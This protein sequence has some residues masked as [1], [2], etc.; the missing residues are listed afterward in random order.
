MI[1]GSLEIELFANVARLAQD[2]EQVKKS[3]GGA[4]GAVEKA[5][6]VAR[7]ALIGLGA[8]GLATAFAS[9]VKGAID[10]A[11]SLNKLSQRSGVAVETLSQLQ[12]AA[13][14]ADVSNESLNTGLKKLNQS[15]A[16]GLAGDKEKVA[17]FKSLGITLTDTA[18]SAKTA[19]T[20]L[21]EMADTFSKAKDGAGKTAASMGLL[22]KAGDEMIPLLNG[23]S[24]ALRALMQEADKLGL[25]ISS[26]FAKQAEEF[27]DNLT[28]V[29]V[30]G[31]KAAI[32]FGQDFVAGLGKAMKA[33][34]DA[35]VEGGRLA[36]VIAGLQTLLTGDDRHKNNVAMAEQTER[37]LKAENELAELQSRRVKNKDHVEV[38]KTRVAAIKA[39]LDT[40][41]AYR[42]LMDEED[43]KTEAAQKKVEAAKKNAAEIKLANANADKAA[44]E[45]EKERRKAEEERIKWGRADAIRQAEDFRDA[46]EAE[47]KATKEATKAIEE[48]FKARGEQYQADQKVVDSARDILKN[49][50]QETADLALSNVERETA[51]AL[52]ELE[53]SK[54][55][56]TSEAYLK[57]KQAI[58]EAVAAREA[59]REHKR[60]WDSIDQTAHDVFV[61]I[62]EGGSNAF[63]KLG[64]TLK[65]AVLDL[66]YQMTVKKWILQFAAT[67][68]GQSIGSL[69][70]GASGAGGGGGGLGSLAGLIPGGGAFSSGLSAGF[71]ALVGEGGLMGGLSAGTTALGAGNIMGGLGTLAG[72]LG[73]IAIG[74]GV[75]ASLLKGH[76][77]TRS[78]GQYNFGELIAAPSGG[79]I[80]QAGQAAATTAATIDATLA[81]LGSGSR[82]TNFFSGLESSEKGKGFAY[83]GFTLNTG[84][85]GG[86]GWGD[87]FAVDGYMNRRGNMTTEQAT[88]AFTTELKQATLQAIQQAA[89]IPKSVAKMLEGRDIDAMVDAELDPLLAKI[90]E[91]IAGVGRLREAAA[92]LP[93]ENLTRL[94]FDAAASL[95]EFSGGVENLVGNLN[96]YYSNFF[97][98]EEQRIQTAK[99]I[100]RTLDAAGGTFTLSQIL[101]GNR[102]QFRQVVEAFENRTDEAGMKFYAALLSVAGA[103]ASITPE[104][105]AASE[106]TTDYNDA[107]RDQVSLLEDSISKWEDFANSL[108]RF[109]KELSTGPLAQNS[110]YEQYMRTGAEFNRL[111]AMD[112]KS[113][114]RMAGLE[115]AGRAFL[116]ASQAYNA[117]STAYFMDLAKVKG[118]V[119][120][121]ELAARAQAD[122][123][124]LQ[125]STLQAQLGV[126]QVIQANTAA[127]AAGAA[128]PPSAAS[129]PWN[130]NGNSNGTGWAG[131]DSSGGWWGPAGYVPGGVATGSSTSGGAAFGASYDVGTNYVPRDMMAL[132]HEGE[133]VVPKAYNPAAGGGDS[134]EVAAI[135]KTVVA[136]LDGLTNVTAAGARQSGDALGRIVDN[137]GKA[138]RDSLRATTAAVELS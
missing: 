66:L 45:A 25:T 133:A 128:A 14:L 44:A 56:K 121:S 54:I 49:I 137:T 125:L 21:L 116:E 134:G 110:P 68:S 42:K 93:F 50:Q 138:A 115:E 136:R 47:A 19:D 76:G 3:V 109:L 78:G 88:A 123:A 90:N 98:G 59:A 61:N 101:A 87:G 65:A 6:S 118:A 84:G 120:A 95:I 36:G 113:E 131:T 5:A 23:G 9:S 114:E 75:V 135:L 127:S 74:L 18:G 60:I 38:L 77:E 126:L 46:G 22:G 107:L 13:K 91:T 16:Q 55:D 17:L 37:L 53:A 33:M 48:F 58:P 34:A 41:M 40:T 1:A 102:S 24:E 105:Q 69:V 72:T 8:V 83:A 129:N 28:K 10:L 108:K 124:R 122:I 89:D 130:G 112:P 111:A 71:G 86:Q 94:T 51:I 62:F 80:G 29:Q 99:N 27:N 57:L 92:L 132:I 81:A 32:L 64:Q 31:Q 7:G 82:L 52:R 67:G 30:A 70:S 103:F 100:K 97:S 119:E 39:E 11:D 63:K 117:T 26:D 2:M 79:Q 12:Y 15:I 4:M 104:A 43:A 106:A 96:A 85:L 20:V 73:P 35:T